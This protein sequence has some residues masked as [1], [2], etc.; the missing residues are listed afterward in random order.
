MAGEA[1]DLPS[2]ASC[3]CL[4]RAGGVMRAMD[5]G[6]RLMAG[7]CGGQ[8]DCCGAGPAWQVPGASIR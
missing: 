4:D 1:H 3:C 5:G 8:D 2:A 7:G 6:V